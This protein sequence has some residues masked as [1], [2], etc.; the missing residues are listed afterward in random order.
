MHIV[1]WLV[2]EIAPGSSM[3]NLFA[4]SPFVIWDLMWKKMAA[5]LSHTVTIKLF[6]KHMQNMSKLNKK[7]TNSAMTYNKYAVGKY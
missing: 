5:F 2:N 3:E 4:T 1:P 6:G 7:Q